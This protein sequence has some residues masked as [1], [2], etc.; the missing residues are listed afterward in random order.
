VAGGAVATPHRDRRAR[1]RD[2][3][4]SASGLIL[5][6]QTPRRRDVRPNSSMGCPKCT[7]PLLQPYAGLPTRSDRA[8]I[9]VDQAVTR[10]AGATAARS[11]CAHAVTVAVDPGLGQCRILDLCHRRGRWRLV[12][13]IDRRR[14]E[15][16]RP[17][18]GHRHALSRKSVDNRG[19]TARRT[20][21]DDYLLPGV[22]GPEPRLV[23][24][25]AR[26]LHE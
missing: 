9:G 8:G 18:Q 26:A 12:N 21:L 10:P 19:H 23:H 11:A 6:G 13:P 15:Y 14:P 22:R 4:T 17:A 5:D 24:G 2:H 16:G 20:T 3:G 25:D 7:T 1:Q